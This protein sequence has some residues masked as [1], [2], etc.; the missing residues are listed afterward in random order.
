MV[1][2][3]LLRL[4][5][6]RDLVNSAQA[7]PLMRTMIDSQYIWQ[8]LCR[9]H[10]TNQQ[11]RLALESHDLNLTKRSTLRGVKYAR[12]SSS[13]GRSSYRSPVAHKQ[14]QLTI[15]SPKSSTRQ[16]IEQTSGRR[17]VNRKDS[18][19]SS[20]I[21]S[22]YVTKAIRIFDRDEGGSSASRSNISFDGGQSR[23][24]NSNIKNELNNCKPLRQ[25]DEKSQ[26]EVANQQQ[27]QQSGNRTSH[28]IDWERVFHQLR[29]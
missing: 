4:N 2:E 27:Q 10:F 11:L 15:S 17:N 22:S 12:T 25:Y 21:S 3:I 24:H 13:D 9:Y 28:E 14:Q 7:S 26:R 6:Y 16:Q 19:G 18:S 1:R 20:S 8:Q 23:S 5:D 29:K